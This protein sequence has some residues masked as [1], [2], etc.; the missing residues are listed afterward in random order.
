MATIVLSAAGFALGGPIGA[1]L[2]SLAG[3]ALDSQIFG[4]SRVPEGPRLK[5]LDVQTSSYGSEIPAVFGSMRVAGTVIWATDLIEQQGEEDGGK[6]S[7]ARTVYSYSASLAVALSSRPAARVGRIWADGNLMR[8]EAS[9]FKVGTEFRFHS[10]HGD[11]APDSLIA[12][13]EGVAASGFRGIAYAVFEDLQLADYGNRIPS[14]SFELIERD[15]SVRLVEIAD[16]VTRGT[17]RGNDPLSVRGFAAGGEAA[18]LVRIMVDAAGLRL[19]RNADGFRLSSDVMGESIAREPV[20]AIDKETLDRP[21]RS[22]APL[23]DYPAAVELRYYDLARDYQA[24]LQRARRAGGGR[25]LAAFDFPAA[26][27][28]GLAMR[29]AELRAR[30]LGAER[31]QLRMAV[32]YTVDEPRAGTAINWQNRRWTITEIEHRRGAMLLTARSLVRS[33]P[34]AAG[35][36]AGRAVHETDSVHGPTRLM[37]VEL[38][39]IAQGGT[40]KPVV[41]IAAAG[42]SS[43]WRRAALLMGSSG[44]SLRSIGVTAPAAVMGSLATILQAVPA[45][46]IDRRNTPEIELLHGGMILGDADRDRL[47]SGANLAAIGDEV[48]QFERAVQTGDRR[49]RL[50][51]LH[52]G[53]YG[54]DH[55]DGDHEP[56]APF[57]LL[58]RDRLRLLEGPEVAA[59]LVLHIAAT[60]IGDDGPA[61]A[62]ASLTGRAALPYAPVHLS[63][64]WTLAGDLALR[65]IRRSR[66]GADWSLVVEPPLGEENE[67]YHV[68]VASRSGAVLLNI[69]IPSPGSTLSG[70]V[71]DGW[72]SSG[73]QSIRIAVRQTGRNGLSPPTPIQ[74]SLI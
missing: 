45:G 63:A 51:G 55:A 70:P 57:L 60:G 16:A 19:S 8:G 71:I 48:V 20:A 58:Q 47:L 66:L 44:N 62:A 3:R 23:G 2:G 22:R 15:G 65:W 50:Q 36:I 41:A 39:D 68:E 18:D 33:A 17:V 34:I 56:G 4:G 59:G 1:A 11:Q 21:A 54:S 9:D 69:E 74:V 13:A 26:M 64:Q 61:M 31:E 30:R 37:L 53:L 27:D 10:G 43:G 25:G 46:L 52:R 72:R 12:Q 38:P 32:P 42:L 14:F 40:D 6:N 5:E 49:Y 29:L 7:P 24:G 35:G 73:E 28:A 67:G